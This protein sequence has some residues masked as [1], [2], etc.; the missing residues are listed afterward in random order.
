MGLFPAEFRDQVRKLCPGTFEIAV[1]LAS[2]LES[3]R[4]NMESDAKTP[5]KSL[6]SSISSIAS[7]FEANQINTNR[8][9]SDKLNALSCQIKAA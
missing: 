3:Q 4:T 2:E 9:L 7:T 8:S 1:Y 5:K 6:I